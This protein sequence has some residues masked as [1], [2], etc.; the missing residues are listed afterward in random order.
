V[1][2]PVA[3]STRCYS[4]PF[5][6]QIRPNGPGHPANAQSFACKQDPFTGKYKK[7]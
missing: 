2:A 3:G 4:D 5:S 7:L 1:K 6:G